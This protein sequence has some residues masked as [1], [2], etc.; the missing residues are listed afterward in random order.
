M[1][2]QIN[3][4]TNNNKT[5]EYANRSMKYNDE[6][7]KNF[8]A[9][10]PT[11]IIGDDYMR[12]EYSQRMAQ[13]WNEEYDKNNRLRAIEVMPNSMHTEDVQCSVYDTKSTNEK[14]GRSTILMVNR[15][16]SMSI[17]KPD[18]QKVGVVKSIFTSV[19][20][21]W[22]DIFGKTIFGE[23]FEPS[24]TLYAFLLLLYAIGSTIAILGMWN[25]IDMKYI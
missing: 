5:N 11:D 10:Y 19:E 7:E 17:D 15:I 21:D 16:E 18:D 14:N 22:N 1:Y 20:F 8:I 9:F 6:K 3:P 25:I 23:D 13:M 24:I 2:A 12:L 4:T